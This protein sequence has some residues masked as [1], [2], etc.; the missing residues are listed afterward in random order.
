MP[1]DVTTRRVLA[2]DARGH[3]PADGVASAPIQAGVVA[4]DGEVIGVVVAEGVGEG[5][6]SVADHTA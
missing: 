4:G 6:V 5:G 2:L 1:G 3:D